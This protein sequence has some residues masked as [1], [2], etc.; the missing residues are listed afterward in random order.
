MLTES[1]RFYSGFPASGGTQHFNQSCTSPWRKSDKYTFSLQ[2]GGGITFCPEEIPLFFSSS[3]LLTFA[4]L[5]PPSKPSG[6]VTRAH[7]TA[8][9]TC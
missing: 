2:P 9:H 7:F 6:D 8:S 5:V 4:W 1:L 3:F